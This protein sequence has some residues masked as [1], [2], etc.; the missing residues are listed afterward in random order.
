MSPTQQLDAVLGGL[1][2]DRAT[3]S[4]RVGRAGCV[5]LSGG[6]VTYVESTSAPGVEQI[7]VTSGRVGAATMRSA[8]QS[9]VGRADGGETLVRQGLLA[10]GE[11]Q[12][13]VLGAILDAAFFVLAAKGT[14]PRFKEGDRHWLGDQWYFDT[15]G[16]LRECRRRRAQ[17]DHVWPYPDV[18]SRPVVITPRISAQR[19]VLTS[20]QWEVLVSADATATPI[21][22]ARRLGRPAYSV[23]LAVRQLG[24]AGLLLDP[25]GAQDAVPAAGAPA[26][27]KRAGRT[28]PRP[29]ALESRP[30]P[31]L[32]QVSGDPT[33]VS[34]LIRL[35][36]A[37]ERLL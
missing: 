1:A 3:G 20:L 16:L 11:L 13:C 23:L 22:L 25:V 27:P 21:D 5:Y 4:L 34:V 12:L 31:G 29:G 9:A 6:R 26:L 14:R 15:A 30:V 28:G 8:R 32:P 7:L 36:D 19:V 37:L 18:D 17:L 35:R 24:V 33:D 10:R 2:K